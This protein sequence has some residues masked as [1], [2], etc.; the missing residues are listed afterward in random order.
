M[1]PQKS[2]L[3]LIL[4]IGVTKDANVK[5]APDSGRLRLRLRERLPGK[6]L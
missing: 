4:Y 6:Q 2:D 3:S 5:E 1:D